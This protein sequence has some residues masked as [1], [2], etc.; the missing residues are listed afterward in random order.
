MN[1]A[2][3]VRF[4]PNEKQIVSKTCMTKVESKNIRLGH[5]LARLDCKTLCYLKS[6]DMLKYLIRLL[7]HYL[8]HWE[9]LVLN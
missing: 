9:I 1:R 8:K 4:L 6:A 5:Y 3:L 7:L 2:N